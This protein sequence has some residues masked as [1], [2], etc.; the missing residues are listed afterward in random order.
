MNKEEYMEELRK[1]LQDVVEPEREE[2]LRYCEEYLDEAGEENI[3]QAMD[4]LG[5]PSKFSAQ[6]KAEAA[7]RS[8]EN[9]QKNRKGNSSFHN[10]WLIFLGIMAM[11]LALPLLFAAILL[12]FAFFLVIIS[13]ILSGFI[14]AGAC[15]IASIAFFVSIIILPFSASS[16]IRLGG[17][18]FL[19]GM[20]LLLIIGM[21]QAIHAVIPWFTS[22]VTRL[23]EKAKGGKRH[24]I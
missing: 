5:K 13:L 12:M 11:P 19:L 21:Y 9:H 20:G 16:M 10:I 7:I 23:Y 3:Q 6:I 18:C 14:I 4:E 1:C 15:V 2:A 22:L 24:E 17:G 8:S